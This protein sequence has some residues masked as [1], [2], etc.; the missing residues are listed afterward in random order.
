MLERTCEIKYELVDLL[1]KS[2]EDLKFLQEKVE[3][4]SLIKLKTKKPY[5]INFFLKKE[6]IKINYF[7]S[8]KNLVDYF[9]SLV[10]NLNEQYELIILKAQDLREFSTKII[11]DLKNLIEVNLNLYS[12]FENFKFSKLD[13]FEN[14]L[15]KIKGSLTLHEAERLIKKY[16]LDYRILKE[17][18]LSFYIHECKNLP[19]LAN[20]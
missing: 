1:K 8:E 14:E 17:E 11:L 20:L 4:H 7:E 19:V 12:Y 5:K 16:I 18:L 15:G 3:A 9:Q 2:N 6:K 13:F 10:L